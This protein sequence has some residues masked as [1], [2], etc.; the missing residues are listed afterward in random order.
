MRLTKSRGK[1]AGPGNQTGRNSLNVPGR[2]VRNEI[3]GVGGR[4]RW[5]EKG[6]GIEIG[7]KEKGEE[8]EGERGRDTLSLKNIQIDFPV[9]KYPVKMI[10]FLALVCVGM[11]EGEVKTE[12]KRK[13]SL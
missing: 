4:A 2:F 8:R 11:R 6:K 9:I 13:S 1:R 7:R 5:G 10:H 3:L 12:I